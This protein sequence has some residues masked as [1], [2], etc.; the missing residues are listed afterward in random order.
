MA[1]T[2]NLIDN[3]KATTA[4]FGADGQPANLKFP[5]DI[6][7]GSTDYIK[8]QFYQYKGPFAGN[9]NTGKTIDPETGVESKN[10]VTDLSSYNQSNAEF[11]AYPGV[12]NV[13]FYMPED[14]GTGYRFAWG[15]KEFSNIG[16]NA[17]RGGGALLAGDAGGTVG[18]I[19]QLVK[20]AAGALPTVGAEAI[21]NGINAVGAGSVTTN[22]VIGGS[23]GVILNPNTELLFDGFSLRSFT[24]RF[25]MAPRNKDEASDVR[26]IIGTFKKVASPTFGSNAGGLLDVAGAFKQAFGSETKEEPSTEEATST[27][28]PAI[29]ASKL[30]GSNANYIGVPGLCQPFF[31]KGSGLHP[32]IPQYK[33]CA[34]TDVS[35]NYTPDGVYAT[36]SDGAPVAVELSL[37]FAETKLIYADDISLDG[38]TY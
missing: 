15:G 36:Y 19:G 38:A 25:K 8:F 11:A 7:D 9:Q 18:A 6:F 5:R 20:N 12:S 4:K 1:D 24:L 27:T 10:L 23:L 21:A 34:I 30:S 14:I 28:D 3:L 16:V 17:L 26:A 22:D 35:V 33:V 2:L 31:M 32:Y 29:D 13:I 37:T